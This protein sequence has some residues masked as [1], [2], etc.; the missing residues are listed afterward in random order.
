MLMFRKAQRKQTVVLL[1]WQFHLL[2]GSY[3][4]IDSTYTDHSRQDLWDH[5]KR[6]GMILCQD[7][8]QEVCSLDGILETAGGKMGAGS[9]IQLQE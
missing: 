4:L 2:S 5:G 6:G 3:F 9:V 8:T 7:G 1:L